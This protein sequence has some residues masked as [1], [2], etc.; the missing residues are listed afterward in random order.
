MTDWEQHLCL[1]QFVMSS[2]WHET[3]QQTPFFLNHGRSPKIPADITIPH[4]HVLE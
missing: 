1:A 4:R 2:A 3:I